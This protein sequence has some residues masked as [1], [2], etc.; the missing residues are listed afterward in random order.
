MLNWLVFLSYNKS[1]SRLQRACSAAAAL[2]EP[3]G[4]TTR[5][6]KPF[7]VA[8]SSVFQSSI[9]VGERRSRERGSSLHKLLAGAFVNHTRIGAR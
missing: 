2:A 6:L 8:V 3:G 1:V 4:L 9:R 5:C 7:I